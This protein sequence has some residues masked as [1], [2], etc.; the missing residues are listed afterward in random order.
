VEQDPGAAHC[1]AGL[2]AYELAAAGVGSGSRR[3]SVLAV[4]GAVVLVAAGLAMT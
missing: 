2:V 4:L 3:D 1:P